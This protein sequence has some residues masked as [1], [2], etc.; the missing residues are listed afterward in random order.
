MA[1]IETVSPESA[2]GEIAD[3]YEQ[4]K[5]RIG[6]IPNSH[7][8][9]SANPLVLRQQAEYIQSIMQHKTLSP[10]LMAS[11]RVLVSQSTQCAYCVDRNTHMLVNYFGWTIDQVAATKENYMNSPLSDKEKAL[12]GLVIQS[13]KDSHSVSAKDIESMHGLGWTDG[14]IFDAIHHGA[15]MVAADIVIN[16]FKVEMD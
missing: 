12:L 4:T 7:V 10:A 9:Y 14:D 1:I 3:I 16:A 15:R 2:T 5:Q 6:Y 13:V 11:I 8:L